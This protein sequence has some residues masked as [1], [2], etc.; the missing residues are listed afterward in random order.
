MISEKIKNQIK[1]LN[2]PDDLK[3]LLIRILEEEDKG[4]YKY[5]E[6]YDK[7]VTEYLTSKGGGSDDKN[8]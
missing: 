2:L 7:L 5:K 3:K 6:L 4:T 8:K 1:E